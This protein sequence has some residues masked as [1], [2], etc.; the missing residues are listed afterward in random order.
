MSVV[1]R[2][3]SIDKDRISFY[4]DIYHNKKRSYEFLNIHIPTKRLSIEDKEKKEIAEKI[5]SQ[6]EY[7]L[8]VQENGLTDKRKSKANVIVFLNELIEEGKNATSY[9]RVLSRLEAFSEEKS[10]VTFND[11]DY[12]YLMSFQKW[13]QSYMKN[14]SVAYIMNAFKTAM[15]RAIE[16]KIIKHNPLNEIPKSQRLRN[17]STQR[18]HLEIHELQKLATTKT[19]GIHPQVK[20]GYLLSAFCGMRWSDI[21]QL[22]WANISTKKIVKREIWTIN[23]HPE[24]KLWRPGRIWSGWLFHWHKRVYSMRRN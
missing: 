17:K 24:S 4:L 2:E 14:N 19:K 20:Q 1:L 16:Q 7:E 9:S 11:L 15:N 18:T 3:K 13:L 22:C 5:R 8:L 21:Y 6:R 12:D 10:P 23:F